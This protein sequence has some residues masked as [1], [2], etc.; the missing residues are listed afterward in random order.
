MRKYIAP[1]E[2]WNDSPLSPVAQISSA[3]MSVVIRWLL[4][5]SEEERWYGDETERIRASQAIQN[6]INALSGEGELQV[7]IETGSIIDYAVSTAPAGWLLCDGSAVSRTTYEALFN[8][9]GTTYGAGDGSTTFN[10]PDCRGRI[11]AGLDGSA[12]RIVGSQAD[13]IGGVLGTETTT[14]SVAQIPAHRHKIQ[15]VSSGSGFGT[16]LANARF[17]DGTI[18]W[19]TN[20]EPS[21]T[22]EMY[23][24]NLT[25]EGGGQAHSNLQPT[26]FLN[27]II[28]T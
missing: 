6:I 26:I 24:N 10:V 3:W 14:L 20:Q 19:A 23:V 21:A 7:S 4:W 17:R 27:K 15:G 16:G 8:L 18:N 11:T 9:I 2:E 5:L 25:L 28:K 13:A 22:Y 12:N 1:T